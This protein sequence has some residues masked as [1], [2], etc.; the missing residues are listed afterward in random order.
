MAVPMIYPDTQQGKAST[1]LEFKQVNKSYIS[2]AR[3]VIE[4]AG[5]KES[6]HIIAESASRDY[7]WL[8]LS[9]GW[10]EGWV[11]TVTYCFY[12]G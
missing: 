5:D 2:Q 4:Y 9:K 7:G 12:R 8:L 1:C 6:A 10:V 11:Q 3:T